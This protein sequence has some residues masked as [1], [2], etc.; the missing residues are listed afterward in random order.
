[1]C[2]GKRGSW[3]GRG[4]GRAVRVVMKRQRSEVRCSDVDGSH[5][6]PK[7][8]REGYAFCTVW[9]QAFH[10]LAL[11]PSLFKYTFVQT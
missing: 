8:C 7:T 11:F 4:R 1:M 5:G 6:M 3:L 2:G 9:V 10:I